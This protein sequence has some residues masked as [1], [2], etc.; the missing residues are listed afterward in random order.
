MTAMAIA[1]KNFKKS[2]QQRADDGI[3]IEGRPH[4]EVI[5]SVNLSAR[6]SMSSRDGAM[7]Q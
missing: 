4:R 7:G 2:S 5:Y 1:T 6:P 3:R